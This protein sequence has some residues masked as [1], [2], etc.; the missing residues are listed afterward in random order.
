[1]MNQILELMIRR[2]RGVQPTPP[3]P[4]VPTDYV[5]YAPLATDLDDH[6][7]SARTCTEDGWD[8]ANISLETMDGV[9]SVYIPTYAKLTYPIG[10]VVVGDNARTLSIWYYPTF[11]DEGYIPLYGVG[12]EVSDELFEIALNNS[13]KVSFGGRYDDVFSDSPLH[14]G[15]NHMAVT[16]DG[17]TVKVYHDGVFVASGDLPLDTATSNIVIGGR[18][19]EEWSQNQGWYSDAYIYNREL[20]S[21]EIMMLYNS[22]GDA[23]DSSSSISDSSSSIS[24]SSSSI[25]DSSSSVIDPTLLWYTPF[26]S[27]YTEQVS[28]ITGVP[29]SNGICS[30]VSDSRFGGYLDMTK[31]SSGSLT[32]LQFPNTQN[33]LQLGEG[34]FA[35]N[36]WLNAPYW[37]NYGQALISHRGNGTG[38]DNKNG[39]VIFKDSNYTM[40]MRIG[41]SS[42]Q[43][44][45]FNVPTDGE[46]HMCTYIRYDD[47]EWEW[48]LDGEYM[49]GGTG[50]STGHDATSNGNVNVFVGGDGDWGKSAVFKI[51]QLKIW[52]RYLDYEE[53]QDMYHEFD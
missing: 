19:W 12:G 43:C 8:A 3:T 18:P 45:S 41:A 47:G 27:D 36:F 33:A 2:S 4:S 20:S 26:A 32:G 37:N 14:A 52:D 31:Y 46:W 49:E 39:F 6:S 9:P 22:H 30:I 7:I 50:F 16:F 17:T 23:S 1:M 15:W 21:S 28:G 10:D 25:S 11:E 48:Y 5:F 40:D 24:D 13:Y 34:D 51:C 35:I 44:K 38:F 42:A 29:T 53:I